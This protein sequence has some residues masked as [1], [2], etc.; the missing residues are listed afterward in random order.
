[1]KLVFLTIVAQTVLV[2]SVAAQV[3]DFIHPE[4]APIELD[5]W[6][7]EFNA[8]AAAAFSTYSWFNKFEYRIS[9]H[10]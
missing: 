8:S 7:S 2:C 6:R 10:K 9:C 1:M 3:N 4:E 5:D